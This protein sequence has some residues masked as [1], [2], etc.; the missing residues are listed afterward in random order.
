MDRSIYSLQKSRYKSVWY[1]W[2]QISDPKRVQPTAT[3][4]HS[5]VALPQW[6]ATICSS[7]QPLEWWTL[8]ASVRVGLRGR[9]PWA[10]ASEGAY[11]LAIKKSSP[12]PN[13]IC[14]LWPSTINVALQLR[15][16]FSRIGCSHKMSTKTISR[17]PFVPEI[18][19]TR[20]PLY[21]FPFDLWKPVHH[22]RWVSDRR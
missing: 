11:L 16:F 7:V 3:W 19:P 2:S 15:T 20:L 1:E 4:R 9:G 18:L 21:H 10:Y 14:H 17:L 13:T 8:P 22:S 6:K 5:V 12:K